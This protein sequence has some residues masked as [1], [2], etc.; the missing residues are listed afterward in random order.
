MT[1]H[2]CCRIAQRNG[3][4]RNKIGTYRKDEEAAGWQRVERSAVEDCEWLAFSGLVTDQMTASF[5][6][7]FQDFFASKGANFR[8]RGHFLFVGTRQVALTPAGA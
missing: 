2:A 7:F 3:C 5:V 4:D 8:N 1:R 6:K